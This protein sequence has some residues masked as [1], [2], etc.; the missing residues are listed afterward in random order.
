MPEKI[1]LPITG[2]NCAACAARIERELNKMEDIRE[3]RVNFPLKKAV[4]LP[5]TDIE[6]KQIIS[7]IR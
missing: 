2:M 4:I 5:R 3:A 6:L 7:L 1:E